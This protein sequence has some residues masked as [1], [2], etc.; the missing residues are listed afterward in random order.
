MY[1]YVYV[2]AKCSGFLYRVAESF[3]RE[4]RGVEPTFI[5]GSSLVVVAAAH[6]GGASASPRARIAFATALHRMRQP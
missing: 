6:A 4:L 3:E 2:C 5:I 1:V